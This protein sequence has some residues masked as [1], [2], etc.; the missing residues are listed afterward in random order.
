MA[1]S[2]LNKKGRE[3]P[4]FLCH[5]L[6]WFIFRLFCR[7]HLITLEAPPLEGAC[8]LASNHISHFEP[9]IISSFFP[10]PLDWITMEELFDHPWSKR[11]FSGI[12][13]IPVDRFG[14]NPQKNRRSLHT[15][16][17][18][19]TEERAIGICPEGGIRTGPS[20]I[21]EGASMKPGLASISILSNAPVIP[22]VILGSDRLYKLSQWAR[23]PHLWIIIGKAILP[24]S[25]TATKQEKAAFQ[26]R[27]SDAFPALQAELFRR[28][29]LCRDD[30][31]KTA[32]E[33]RS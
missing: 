32:Q 14:T 31:P 16:L 21:L 9:S 8:I 29:N 12:N 33:R 28:F 2:Y 4:Y 13:A 18:R 24:P 10:R 27:L 25:K 23:R 26:N 19:L 30:L 1:I 20:S 17:S 5:K 7:V 22:C 3:L 6:T 11:F 15:I